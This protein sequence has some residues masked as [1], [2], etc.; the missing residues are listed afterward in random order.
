MFQYFIG[1]TDWSAF[2]GPA[3]AAC[4]HNIVPLARDDGVLLPITYDFDAAG[5][6]AASY[7]LPD[8]R[9]RIRSVRERLY[10]GSCRDLAALQRS[11]EPFEVKRAEIRALYEQHPQLSAK[12]REKALEYIDEFYALIAEPK[13]VERA[14]GSNCG[15]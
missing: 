1:N 5:I 7:A 14:F 13:R 11:F 12:S 4:C 9:L 15:G 2:A 8:E 10:R 6:V 3:G